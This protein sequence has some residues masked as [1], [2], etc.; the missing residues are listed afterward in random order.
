M[1]YRE[2]INKLSPDD[3]VTLILEYKTFEDNGGVIGPSLLRD[4]VEQIMD[5]VQG[6]K[7]MMFPMVAY[8]LIFEAYRI[9]AHVFLTSIA[10]RESQAQMHFLHNAKPISSHSN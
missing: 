7:S 9:M 8:M 1:N 6:P 4:K 2:F 10:E 3:I 5:K